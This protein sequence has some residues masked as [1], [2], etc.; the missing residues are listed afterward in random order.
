MSSKRKQY[1]KEL[2]AKIALEAIKGYSSITEISKEYKVQP[3]QISLWK[4]QLLENLPEIFDNPRGPKTDGNN[5]EL[6]DQ[7]Y[8]QIGKLEMELE[9]LKKSTNHSVET[10]KKLIEPG[11][12][13]LSISE[14]CSLIELPRSSY[15]FEPIG[16]TDEDLETI[17]LI[18][19]IYTDYPFYGLQKSNPGIRNQGMR[20]NHKRILFYL[21]IS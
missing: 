15:Y 17:K 12:E 20:Y 14:Q 8:R 16:I 4:K 21:G 1:S 13:M 11:H 3:N 7:L 2:K 9:W 10:R 19:K 6:T 5:S 18:D